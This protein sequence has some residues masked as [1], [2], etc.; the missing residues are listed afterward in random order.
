MQIFELK[1]E[2]VVPYE[3]NPRI[4]EHAVQPVK[5]SIQEFGFKIPILVDKNN[6]IITGHTRILAAKELGM[7]IIPA[8]RVEDL[9]EEQINAF[10]LAD[11]KVAEYAYWNSEKLIEEI[12]QISS[13][14]MTELFGFF[15]EQK[16]KNLDD[17]MQQP[18][19]INDF[20]SNIEEKPKEELKIK[21]IVM[22]ANED[23]YSVLEKFLKNNGLHYCR[24]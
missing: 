17:F 5:N 13:I 22:P 24:E 21:V 2:E 15:D 10:R 16:F 9:S 20:F 11:N 8:I 12:E 4:N 19:D 23:E 1:I 14:N 7:S 18:D 3:N 6:V